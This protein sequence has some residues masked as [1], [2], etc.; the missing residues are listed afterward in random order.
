M[1]CQLKCFFETLCKL[2]PASLNAILAFKGLAFFTSWT[3]LEQWL[4]CQPR[5][6][7]YVQFFRKTNKDWWSVSVLLPEN[8]RN[9]V[10]LWGGPK[11]SKEQIKEKRLR[12][13]AIEDRLRKEPFHKRGAYLKRAPKLTYEQR[14][15]QREEI[16][17]AERNGE[18][19][20][21]EVN[22]EEIHGGESWR[23]K[24]I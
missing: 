1:N 18:I 10:I 19:E 9:Y 14:W 13:K 12:K 6:P 4:E 16:D 5:Q 22:W 23:V 20:E 7:F 8:T 11:Q 15:Q 3:Y 21:L 24:R 17:E 2:R